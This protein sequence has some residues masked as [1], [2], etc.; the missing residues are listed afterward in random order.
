MLV[1][2]ISAAGLRRFRP[3]DEVQLVGSLAHTR[4]ELAIR[5]VPVGGLERDLVE[6]PL[7]EVAAVRLLQRRSYPTAV[8]GASSGKQYVEVTGNPLHYSLAVRHPLSEGCQ[9]CS[10]L[11]EVV[12]SPRSRSQ[13][14]IR[15]LGVQ[16]ADG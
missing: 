14:Y 16:V 1:S 5:K 6:P 2:V 10:V 7:Q 3:K 9:V 8:N 13:M 12:V 15:D 11:V 4:D